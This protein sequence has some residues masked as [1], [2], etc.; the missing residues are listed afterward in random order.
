M[1]FE[2]SCSC[3]LLMNYD[4]VKKK[5]RHIIRADR[6]LLFVYSL[7]NY[8]NVSNRSNQTIFAFNKL[9][10]L[11]PSTVAQQAHGTIQIKASKILYSSVKM[12]KKREEEKPKCSNM[13]EWQMTKIK[14]F[15][16]TKFIVYCFCWFGWVSYDFHIDII[17]RLKSKW[18][19]YTQPNLDQWY[20]Q[21]NRTRYFNFPLSTIKQQKHQT[22]N[23]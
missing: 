15:K 14:S 9:G 21:Q 1:S 3:S 17:L 2:C 18:I 16:L 4:V 7:L 23:H 13:C 22:L 20:E 8:Y 6:D 5:T 12:K 19:W 10:T 11:I